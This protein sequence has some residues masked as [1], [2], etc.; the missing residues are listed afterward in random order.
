MA[1]ASGSKSFAER[2][3]STV[4]LFAGGLLILS[5]VATVFTGNIVGSG[6]ALPGL[7]ALL[8]AI[9]LARMEGPFKAFGLS[10]NLRP[11]N[12][13][14]IEAAPTSPTDEGAETN[15][16][17]AGEPDEQDLWA[18]PEKVVAK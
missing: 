7:L 2:H 18:V 12:G 6:L 9:V 13:P 17:S 3:G 8:V 1:S 16:L 11:L 5:A 10:G 15:Q 14:P 4:L